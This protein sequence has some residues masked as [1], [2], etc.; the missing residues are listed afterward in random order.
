MSWYRRPRT[1]Q[2]RRRSLDRIDD[3]MKEVHFRPRR[4]NRN[5]P[6]AWD[7]QHVAAPS[8][9]SWKRSSK[10]RYQWKPQEEPRPK[11]HSKFR[12]FGGWVTPVQDRYTREITG[13]RLESMGPRW[14]W[15]LGQKDRIYSAEEI[16]ERGFYVRRW[17]L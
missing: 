12:G 16:A 13:Y 9:R 15:H 4:N 14:H 10:R 11:K 6:D 3:E 1:T 2:E 5:L 8:D 17:L 7:D